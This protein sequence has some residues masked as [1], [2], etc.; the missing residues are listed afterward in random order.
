MKTLKKF[1]ATT[2]GKKFVVAVTG[3]ILFGF[4]AGHMAGNLKVFT[5]TTP[6]GVPHID[7]YG[8]YLKVFGKPVLP[9]MMALWTARTVLLVSVVLHVVTVILLSMQNRRARPVAY[10]QSKKQAAS[11]A[12]LL[13]MVSGLVILAFVVF[14]ILHFTTGTIQLGEREFAHGYVYGN[15]FGSFS[16]WYVSLGYML[17]M[18][19]LGFHLYH[20]VWSM[21]Q[22][23]GLDSPDRNPKLR[24][25]SVAFTVI[26]AA[27][28]ILVPLAFLMGWLP[29]PADYDYS[30]LTNH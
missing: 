28:F 15:L 11:L 14:H 9:K 24:A 17:V 13:M 4:V 12:G 19:M 10:V 30:L 18:V 27:G 23:L 22:T 8:H 7:E 25:F 26:V 5:G 1:Y 21:F 6:E 3:I 2:I 20:G 16:V 29:E